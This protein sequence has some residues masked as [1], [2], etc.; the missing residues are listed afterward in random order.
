[1]EHSLICYYG[2]PIGL[3]VF[4]ISMIFILRKSLNYRTKSEFELKHLIVAKKQDKPRI[5]IIITLS[6]A[7]FS[8]VASLL[9]LRKSVAFEEFYVKVVVLTFENQD[10]SSARQH[11]QSHSPQVWPQLEHLNFIRILFFQEL[12]AVVLIFFPHFKQTVTDF[13]YLISQRTQKLYLSQGPFIIN[14]YQNYNLTN[15]P[16]SDY[17]NYFSYGEFFVPRRRD[18]LFD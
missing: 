10:S 13:G 16:V 17:R 8:L 1:M 5:V 2:L 6:T 9:P 14:Y 4:G 12:R 3:G 7:I 11:I 18:C 15:S